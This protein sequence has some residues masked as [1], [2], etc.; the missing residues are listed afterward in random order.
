[1]LLTTRL[2]GPDPA[3][4]LLIV[5]CAHA[6]V[7]SPPG[8]PGASRPGL[9]QRLTARPPRASSCCCPGPTRAADQDHWGRAASRHGEHEP[10][11]CRAAARANAPTSSTTAASGSV[12]GAGGTNSAP[13][14]AATA[15]STASTRSATAVIRRSQPRTVEAGRPS[16]A[17][18]RRWPHPP[19]LAS[20]AAPITV[21]ASAR[22][23]STLAGSSTWVRRQ[24]THTDRRG[25]SRTRPT[26][27]RTP[28]AW[29]HPHGAMRP[30]QPA[31]G[32]PRP[33]PHSAVSTAERSTPTVITGA[34]P[35]TKTA[36]PCRSGQ[37]EGPSPTT[38]TSSPW[39]RTRPR[40]RT[41]RPGPPTNAY[42]R[43]TTT[44]SSSP[45]VAVNTT[46]LDGPRRS[47]VRSEQSPQ[48]FFTSTH[49]LVI[50]ET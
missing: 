9:P 39:R 16:R 8:P 10:P 12:V 1:M 42:Y 11:N 38:G 35:C 40:A 20:R 50:T 49:S 48:R 47:L 36:L 29:A 7:L 13:N 14:S 33:P 31:T 22:R 6:T 41:K 43:L 28:R 18:T 37:A 4:R 5:G 27:P 46:E 34:L 21:T 32:Q 3:G 23:S 45:W 15:A 26:S 25:R 19:A 17:A 24:P 44:P 2:P 30:P